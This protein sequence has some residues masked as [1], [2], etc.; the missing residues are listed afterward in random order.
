LNAIWKLLAL[1]A[2]RRYYP[3][4]GKEDAM[5]RIIATLE[6]PDPRVRK[7]T[8]KAVRLHRDKSQYSRKRKHKGPWEEP[9]GPLCFCM[10][11]M[12]SKQFNFEMLP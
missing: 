11:T 1:P 3:V 8:A 2:E 7:K 9:R 4:Q 5:S 10:L 12:P 6:L